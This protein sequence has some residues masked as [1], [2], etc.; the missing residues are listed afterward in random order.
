MASIRTHDSHPPHWTSCRI[1]LGCI[2]LGFKIQLA[3]LRPRKAISRPAAGIQARAGWNYDG[4]IGVCALNYTTTRNSLKFN[5]KNNDR[6]WSY[7]CTFL[8]RSCNKGV[9]E[10][11]KISSSFKH[12]DSLLRLR[13]LV[14]REI[15]C[16]C[17]VTFGNRNSNKVCLVQLSLWRALEHTVGLEAP[18]LILAM[19]SNI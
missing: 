16:I 7:K 6:K 4:A 9:E 17:D 5:R 18:C 13:V 12:T 8:N 1:R 19:F 15:G 10:L 14:A 2:E 11:V 3:A